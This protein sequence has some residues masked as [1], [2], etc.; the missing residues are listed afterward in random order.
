M[1]GHKCKS[2]E[3]ADKIF[4]LLFYVYCIETKTTASNPTK[5]CTTM[6]TT[7]YSSPIKFGTVMPTVSVKPTDRWN[8]NFLIRSFDDV[9]CHGD[10]LSSS[11]INRRTST[12]AA[13]KQH[14][15]SV[16][17]TAQSAAPE[18]HRLMVDHV[19]LP[20]DLR[21]TSRPT[22]RAPTSRD[23]PRPLWDASYTSVDVQKDDLYTGGRRT[24]Q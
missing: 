13:S 19:T 9:V 11:C 21:I 4:D 5:F 24:A 8:F 3:Y 2:L 22:S 1:V 20:R 16:C 23:P 15:S 18:T 12:N 14:P 7:E 6:Q 10:N 17:A